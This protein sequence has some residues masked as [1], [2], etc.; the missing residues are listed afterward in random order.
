MEALSLSPPASDSQI[1]L[2]A[3]LLVIKALEIKLKDFIT[4]LKNWKDTAGGDLLR[5][6]I[7]EQTI[8]SMPK[9]LRSCEKLI[10]QAQQAKLPRIVVA[11]TLAF[12]RVSQLLAWRSQAAD[13]SSVQKSEEKNTE[14]VEDQMNTARQLLH[15]ALEHCS[16]LGNS[17]EMKERVQAMLGLFEPRYEEVTPEEL[18]SIKSAMVSGRGGIATHSGHWYRCVNG[19]PVSSHLKLWRCLLIKLLVRDWRVRCAYRRS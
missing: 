9:V 16:Q 3:D 6:W 13:K 12:A 17:D 14:A 18:A 8:P 2:G 5:G 15:K 19:H 10:E 4:F 11:A 1:V 7:K